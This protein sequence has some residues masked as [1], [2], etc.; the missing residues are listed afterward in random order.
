MKR[1]PQCDTG[2]PDSHSTCPTHGGLLSEIRELKPGMVIR[3]NYKIIRKL[4]EGGMGTVYLAHQ[5]LMGEPRALKFLSP[6]LSNDQAFTSRFLREVRTLR[7]VRNRNVVDCGDLER[8]EDDSLFFPMEFVDGPDLRDLM[9]DAGGPLDVPL[10]LEIAHGICEGL[11]AAHARGMVHRDIKPE[12]I[13]MAR[14]GA[15]WVPKIADFGIVATKES[16]NTRTRTG[17][18]LLT[19][20]YAAPEQWRGMPGSE[21]DGRTDL[22]ALGGVLYEMLTGRTAFNAENYE[23]WAEQHRNVA[24][25]PPSCLRPELAKWQ[26]LD[27]LVLY[28]LAKDREER[29]RDVTEVLRLLNLVRTAGPGARRVTQRDETVVEAKS[30]PAAVASRPAAP[31]R[32]ETV[33]EAK[34]DAAKAESK[35][36][37]SLVGRIVLAAFAVAGILLGYG[38]YHHRSGSTAGGDSTNQTVP[39]EPQTQPDQVPGSN[40]AD[41]RPHET[42]APKPARIDN[43]TPAVQKLNI[44]EMAQKAQ[45][46]FKQKDYSQ[47]E[48]L[49]DQACIA[50]FAEACN[51]LGHMYRFNE[52]GVSQDYPKTAALL[53]KACNLGNGD[54]CTQLGELYSS[55]SGVSRD[56]ATESEY[57]RKGCDEGSPRGCYMLGLNY[58][59]G[60]GV[61]KDES[62]VAGLYT[63][64]CDAG[65]ADGCILLGSTYDR[66]LGVAQDYSRAAAAYGRA[67]DVGLSSGNGGGCYF[68]GLKYRDGQ[69]VEQD[70]DKARQ[71]F[72]QACGVKDQRACSLLK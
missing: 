65:Y 51:Q 3:Q 14:D 35:K 22:Y 66:G 11:G 7:Q 69:G 6:E 50:G 62:K 9:H 63:K 20:P 42:V 1:C 64:S 70:T 38:M 21:L 55:G 30:T 26:D 44:S 29:P 28:L 47:A 17:G 67:C 61:Q 25:R 10:A 52:Y 2:F 68:L 56:Y 8:A 58:Q 41:Q 34:A 46:F 27:A 53:L 31:T 23:G 45:E 33:V 15:G 48:P 36:P 24:P 19:M 60:I 4:G 43:S 16:S 59:Y 5:T 72:T 40:P 54:G 71:L 49:F 32:P 12:N 18:T 13:L 57:Y 37:M 39:A